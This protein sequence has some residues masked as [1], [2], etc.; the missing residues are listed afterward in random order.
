MKGISMDFSAS[1]ERFL[2][3]LRLAREVS[4][5][6]LRA[7]RLDLSSFAVFAARGEV[8]K[9]LIRRYLSSLYE[10]KVSVR[11]VL[12]RLSALRSFYKFAMREKLVLENPLEEIDSPK[13][14]QRLPVSISYEQV[15]LLFGQP[16]RATSLRFR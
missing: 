6:T 10:Q 2:S 12:R 13:K 7:Y 5:H 3:Y 16:D 14:E 1:V 11:T 15:E 4:V 8:S 9:R